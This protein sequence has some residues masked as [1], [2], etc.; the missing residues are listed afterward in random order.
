MTSASKQ[1]SRDFPE[2]I[3]HNT[4]GRVALLSDEDIEV[5]IGTTGF[6]LLETVDRR[7]FGRCLNTIVEHTI[8]EQLT[9]RLTSKTVRTLRKSIETY[10]DISRS[11]VHG[12]FYPPPPPLEWME[13]VEAWI[14]KAEEGMVERSLGGAPS[15][16]EQQSFM[17]KTLGLMHAGFGVEP[18]ASTSRHAQDGTG[19]AFRFIVATYS[20]VSAAIAERGFSERVHPDLAAKARWLLP[21][22]DALGKRLQSALNYRLASAEWKETGSRKGN[23]VVSQTV[24]EAETNHA[25]RIYSRQF[26][27]ILLSS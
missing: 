14:T 10:R 21:A 9:S 20:L 24:I 3:D 22:D 11:L 17:P 25:W 5:A 18:D 23:A 27:Q 2:A 13:Q 1:A 6:Q 16:L 19:A 4:L 7:E 26:R 15:N 12:E 8:R